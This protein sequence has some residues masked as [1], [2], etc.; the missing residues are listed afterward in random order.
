MK[1][2]VAILLSLLG[3]VGGLLLAVGLCMCLLPEWNAFTP[4]VVLAAIGAVTLLSMWPIHRSAAGKAPIRLSGG[5]VASALVGLVGAVGLGIG[6]VH[7]LEAVTAFGLAVGIAGIVLMLAAVGIGRKAAGKA[8]I[9]VNGRRVAAYLIGIAGA[10]VLGV[11]MCL[12]MVWSGLLVPGILVGCAGLLTC[13]LNVTLRL[14]K[15][16]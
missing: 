1:K 7:C 6:L 14:T 3:T 11:G 15:T 13:V 4:G 9:A 12:S 10:L 2:R 16:A 5:Y 8:P